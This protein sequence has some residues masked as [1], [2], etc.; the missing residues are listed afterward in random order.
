MPG[1]EAVMKSIKVTEIQYDLKS[2]YRKAN[3]LSERALLGF[4]LKAGLTDDVIFGGA[5]A[6]LCAVERCKG[7]YKLLP[8]CD[9]KENERKILYVVE[10]ALDGEWDDFAISQKEINYNLRRIADY[11]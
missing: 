5:F 10:C 2:M 1:K 9:S 11:Q 6:V 3:S 8:Y 4:M 7:L